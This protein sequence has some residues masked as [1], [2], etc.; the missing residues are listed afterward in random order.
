MEPVPPLRVASRQRNGSRSRLGD[1]DGACL[2]RRQK[3]QL[4]AFLFVAVVGAFFTLR[5]EATRDLGQDTAQDTCSRGNFAACVR[6]C[7]QLELIS[8][9]R[10]VEA[11]EAQRGFGGGVPR[12]GVDAGGDSPSGQPDPPS[13]GG[14]SEPVTNPPAAPQPSPT[15]PQRPTPIRDVTCGLAGLL[16]P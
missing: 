12:E 11:R 3:V 7:S 13:E 2:S 14:G 6:V 10:C 9:L 4:I 15:E 16:C 1:Q 8:N 5:N